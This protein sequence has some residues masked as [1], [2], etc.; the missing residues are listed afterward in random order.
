M[1]L[2]AA[3]AAPPARA[4]IEVYNRNGFTLNFSFQGA[5]AGFSVSNIDYGV[6]NLD[7]DLSRRRSDRQW[8]EYFAKPMLSG[9]YQT[10]RFGNFYFGF[11]VITSGTFGNGDAVSG[12]AP[13]GL[14]STS[15]LNQGWTMT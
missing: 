13:Q 2:A 5:L 1:A 10:E 15:S 4:D 3:A 14:R 7:T 11:S 12:L 9:Q 8:G 6:G